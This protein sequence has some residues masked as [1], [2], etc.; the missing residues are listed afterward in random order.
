V[1]L[2]SISGLTMRFGGLTAVSDFDLA[3]ERGE[4]VGLIGPNGSGKT[5]VFNMVTGFYKPTAGRV[6]FDDTDITGRRPDQV[7]AA[8]IARIFQNNRLFRN[9]TVFDNVIIGT[10]FQ[11]HSSPWAAIARLPSYVREEHKACEEAMA[12][13]AGLGLADLVDEPAGK[14]PFGLQRRLEV[15][16]ALSTKP[17]LLLL[18]E[19]AT[20]MSPEETSEMMDFILKIHQD[21]DL[22]IFLIEHHMP[23]VMGC[24]PRIL[25]LNYGKTIAHG[26]PA[27]IQSNDEVIQAYLGAEEEC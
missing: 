13:L 25:V 11:L 17:K 19:P 6:F 2:L 4:I 8:G 14:L 27:E 7:T 3:M 15:A 5:T 9:L 26:T 16:R 1:S 12:L 18:D 10:H 23:V 20:G 22:T 24:C 21:F